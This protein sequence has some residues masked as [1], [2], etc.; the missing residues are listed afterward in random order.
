MT[1]IKDRTNWSWSAA[2]HVY[3][4]DFYSL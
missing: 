1:L 3:A 2:L 4:A